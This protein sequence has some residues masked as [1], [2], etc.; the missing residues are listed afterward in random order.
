M[1]CADPEAVQGQGSGHRNLL[2]PASEITIPANAIESGMLMK[3][4]I[5][6]FPDHVSKMNEHIGPGHEPF[7]EIFEFTVHGILMRIRNHCHLH[8]PTLFY[9]ALRTAHSFLLTWW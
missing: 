1:G 5:H 4:A 6:L 2:G 9:C 7:V 8:I 3:K